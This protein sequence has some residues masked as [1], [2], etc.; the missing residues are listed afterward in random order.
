MKANPL[1]F[2]LFATKI[3]LFSRFFTPL[4]ELIHTGKKEVKAN[5]PIFENSPIP[6]HNKKSGTRARGGINLKKL[7]NFPNVSSIEE[8]CPVIIP[9]ET[10]KKIPIKLPEIN[11]NKLVCKSMNRFSDSK[12]DVKAEICR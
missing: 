5:K 6:N 8:K 7:I 2:K 12:I 11:L 1:I 9:T 4:C 3:Y 10:P